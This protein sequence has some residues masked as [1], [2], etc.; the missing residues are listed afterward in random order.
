[1]EGCLCSFRLLLCKLLSITVYCFI[2]EYSGPVE[3]HLKKKEIL[4]LLGPYDI[5]IQVSEMDHIQWINIYLSS[6]IL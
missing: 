2:T 6:C 1:M 5:K 3:P 4:V